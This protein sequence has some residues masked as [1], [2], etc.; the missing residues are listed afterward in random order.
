[1]LLTC[2]YI[3]AVGISPHPLLSAPP[4]PQSRPMNNLDPPSVHELAFAVEASEE[5]LATDA[6]PGG[7]ASGSLS[8]AATRAVG[9]EGVMLAATAGVSTTNVELAIREVE[10]DRPYSFDE[11]TC[12]NDGLDGDAA[13]TGSGDPGSMLN[14]VIHGGSDSSRTPS[15]INSHQDKWTTAVTKAAAHRSEQR[16]RCHGCRSWWRSSA[17]GKSGV[18]S[19]VLAVII[20]VYAVCIAAS[21]IVADILI[22]EHITEPFLQI[23]MSVKVVVGSICVLLFFFGAWTIHRAT[24]ARE[25]TL[26]DIA[27]TAEARRDSKWFAIRVFTLI[28]EE[29]GPNSP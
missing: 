13:A 28:Q 1:M 14:G 3:F 7:E 9:T 23:T 18:F 19:V 26:E 24:C 16:R 21:P 2:S 12:T 5:G 20:M 25:S 22:G 29:K 8:V 27:T 10:K 17:G 15:S 11:K 4:S 6:P